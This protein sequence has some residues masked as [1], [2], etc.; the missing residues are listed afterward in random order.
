[1]NIDLNNIILIVFGF[2]LTLLLTKPVL[3]LLYKLNVGQK[4]LD[5]TPESHKKKAGTPTMGGILIIGAFLICIAITTLLD[6][7]L[8]KS[9]NFIIKL[10]PLLIFALLVGILGAV[11]DWLT[12]FP[13]KGVRGIKSQVKA[14]IQLII[15]LG[16][17]LYLAFVLQKTFNILGFQLT[18]IWY[19][20]VVTLF[21]SGFMNFVNLT[22]GLDG[23][24]AG[25]MAIILFVFINIQ[26]VFLIGVL[27]GFLVTNSNVAKMF[28]G[29]TGSLFL[30]AYLIGLAFMNDMG[31]SIFIASGWYLIEG[32]SVIIQWSYFKWTKKKYGEGRRIF[33]MTPIHHH[34]EKSGYPEQKITVNV[35]IWTFILSLIAQFVWVMF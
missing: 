8:Y 5:D 17:V 30:G 7:I 22:D 25:S 27:L 23:L 3:A 12:V 10:S 31:W 11:D 24:L 9:F 34:F 33:K 6:Y 13:R 32:F 29:D 18:G 1:M 21:I 14:M 35:W 19:V 15:T 26:S 20:I 16:F 4:I 28:M 2:V